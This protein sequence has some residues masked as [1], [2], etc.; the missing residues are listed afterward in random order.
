[1]TPFDPKKPT[2]DP[3]MTPFDPKMTP[4][5]PYLSLNAA[6]PIN[7]KKYVCEHCQKTYS[8]NSHLHRHRRKCKE[9]VKVDDQK[10]LIVFFSKKIEEERA[11]F[12]KESDE[13]RGQIESLL[14]KVG[15]NNTDNSTTN[16]NCQTINIGQQ[17]IIVNSFGQEKTDYITGDFLQKLLKTPYSS[18]PKLIKNVHFHPEHPEN[19]NVKITNRKLPYASVWNDD[20]WETRD[21]KEVIEDIVEKSYNILDDKY[22]EEPHYLAKQKRTNYEDFQKKYDND[23][24]DTHKTINKKTEM[25]IID[26]TKNLN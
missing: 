15:S 14:E 8:K 10:S 16:S 6:L 3:K 11:L 2:F 12:R 17:N 13:L 7:K 24:K 1:M 21:K 25:L 22:D 4:F 23:D 18:V 19:H 5:D 9:K 20:K 26:G